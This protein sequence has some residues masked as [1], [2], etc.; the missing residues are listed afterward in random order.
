MNND[1]KTTDYYWVSDLVFVVSDV[2]P[3][4]ILTVEK[5]WGKRLNKDFFYVD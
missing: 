2:K 1:F 5:L 3:H 4:T